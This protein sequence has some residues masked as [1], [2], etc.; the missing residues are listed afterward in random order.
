[1]NVSDV[2]IR[3]VI[4]IEPEDAIAK[5]VSL[6]LDNRVHQLPVVANR[7]YQGMVYAKNLIETNFFPRR[8]KVQTLAVNTTS[9]GSDAQ[10]WEA[11]QAIIRSG[12][13]A[14]PVIAKDR[15]IGIVSETDLALAV[16]VGD[17]LVDDVM[18]GAIVAEEDSTLSYALSNMKRQNISRL[19]VI[20]K[21][22]KLVGVIDTLDIVQVLAVPRERMSASR[23]TML[24][25][26]SDR[27]D[28]RSVKVKEI[29]R[30]ATPTRRGAKLSDAVKLLARAEEIIVIDNDMPVGI[31]APKDVIKLSMPERREP[32]V[33]IAHV[34]DDSEK[35]EIITELNKFL[36]RIAGRF[37]RVYSM[38]VSVDRHRTRKY[39]MHGKLMTT[40]GLVAAR[41]TGWD[42]R[43]ASRELV[44]RL[45][46]RIGDY[47]HDRRRGPSKIR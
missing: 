9:L 22:G 36:K 28:V 6:M 43:S 1:M 32:I 47:K 12:L 2:M 7:S 10:I 39:S 14:L 3:D 30:K 20:S 21:N 11:N 37:D 27:T 31:I 41:S 4:S 34:G 16:D 35:Q 13:R 23:T 44:N 8:T 40:E 38:E 45:D 42:V 24:S 25:A 15:L 5:A 26:G 33:Q 46:R 19:P 17:T 18:I 29:M